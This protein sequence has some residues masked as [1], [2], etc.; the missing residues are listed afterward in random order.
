MKEFAYEYRSD[1]GCLREC[2]IGSERCEVDRLY[3]PIITFPDE[4][5]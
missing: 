2:Y 4:A 1:L 5:P 3:M